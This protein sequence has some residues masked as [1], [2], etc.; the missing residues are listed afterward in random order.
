MD[1]KYFA[2]ALEEL[3]ATNPMNRELSVADLTLE[4]LSQLLRRAQALKDADRA[5][6]AKE[7]EESTRRTR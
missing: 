6:R 5:A 7:A 3:W 4:E 1:T 2:A